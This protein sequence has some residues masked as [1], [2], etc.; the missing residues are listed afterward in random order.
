MSTFDQL[1]PGF[2]ESCKSL[3]GHLV[4]VGMAL[5]VLS[6]AFFFWQGVPHPVELI[7]FITLLTIIVIFIQHAFAFITDGQKIIAQFVEANVPAR[8]DQVA[9]RYR[10]R[11]SAAQG[12]SEKSWWEMLFSAD[13]FEAIIYALLLL[14]SWVAMAVLFYLSIFQSVVL[15]L[16]WVLSP[17]LL[18]CFA[19]PMLSGLALRHV[20]RI[21]GVL[22]WPIGLA[23]AATITD[24]LIDLQTDQNFFTSLPVGGSLAYVAVNLMAVASIGLWILV[25]SFLAPAW[26]QRLVAGQSG[27]AG[28]WSRTG[29]LLAGLA[30]PIAA[31][32]VLSAVRGRRDSSASH[33]SSPNDPRP[34]LIPV[35]EASAGSPTD[36]PTVHP[37]SADDPTADNAVRQILDGSARH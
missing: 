16:C 11:L 29:S 18:A 5:L 13:F 6:F 31:S 8:P 37:L 36:P 21:L 1:F 4:P 23:L 7:K 10:E 12:D 19:I 2:V 15:Y 35:P 30:L 14:V 22:L 33:R 34:T 17:P 27:A 28:L 32:A 9:E 26:I 25:S 24:G 3:H 20:L